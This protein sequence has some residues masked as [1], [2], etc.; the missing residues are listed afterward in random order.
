MIYT[1]KQTVSCCRA[2]VYCKHL[3]Q[4]VDVQDGADLA[5]VTLSSDF[6][7]KPLVEKLLLVS[8]L[9]KARLQH[10]LL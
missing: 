6:H 8:V 10:V 5:A 9:I 3:V 4:G 2:S 1:A 7:Q